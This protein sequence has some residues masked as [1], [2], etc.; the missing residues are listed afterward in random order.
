MH[1]WPF[2]I[3]VWALLG[4]HPLRDVGDLHEKI[5]QDIVI[6]WASARPSEEIEKPH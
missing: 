3:K 5:F 4:G 1:S 6:A 2:A